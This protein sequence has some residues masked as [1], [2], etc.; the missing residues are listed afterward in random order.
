[1]VPV[2][3]LYPLGK[4]GRMLPTADSTPLKW[5]DFAPNAASLLRTFF[6]SN[7]IVGMA[8]ARMSMR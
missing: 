8:Y 1:V 7:E 3:A 5:N 4:D 6:A 2:C